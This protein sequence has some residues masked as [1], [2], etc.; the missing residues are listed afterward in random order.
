MTAL[1]A[2][3]GTPTRLGSTEPAPQPDLRVV[4]RRRRWPVVVAGFVVILVLS[5]MLGAA[6]FHTQ[7]AE[8]QLEIDALGARVEAERVKYDLLRNSIAGKQNPEALAEKAGELGLTRA[9]QPRYLE[10]GKWA[11]AVQLAAAGPEADGVGHVIVDA[12]AL[13]Q[14]REVKSLS[15]GQP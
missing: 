8:R 6:V 15:A 3:D 9:E 13:D 7:L 11:L 1:S 10:V 2:V 12:S 4:G 14:F 5:A